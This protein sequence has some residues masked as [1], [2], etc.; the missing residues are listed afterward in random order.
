[1]VPFLYLFF[2]SFFFFSK[3]SH[4]Y[5]MATPIRGTEIRFFF[6]FRNGTWRIE[7]SLFPLD[8]FADKGRKEGSARL[9]VCSRVLPWWVDMSVCQVVWCLPFFFCTRVLFSS[10]V[11]FLWLFKII[12]RFR[13]GIFVFRAVGR[14]RGWRGLSW[15]WEGLLSKKKKK[16]KVNY[17]YVRWQKWKPVSSFV[18]FVLILIPFLRDG[19]RLSGRGNHGDATSSATSFLLVMRRQAHFNAQLS[20]EVLAADCFERKDFQVPWLLAISPFL[21][22]SLPCFNMGFPCH[23]F[24][25]PPV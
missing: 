7:R 3:F 18:F 8:G 21:L 2:F 24:F 11:G 25:F 19:S 16:R 15:C 13:P 20:S 6:F 17:A 9:C 12:W 22:A 23:L 4:S 10:Q 14:M 5:G 1:M